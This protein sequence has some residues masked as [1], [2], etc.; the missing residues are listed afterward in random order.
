MCRLRNSLILQTHRRPG[1]HPCVLSVARSEFEE[2]EDGY[3]EG[4]TH[5]VPCTTHPS[6]EIG[7]WT[8]LGAGHIDSNVIHSNCFR[9]SSKTTTQVVF[10]N[11][12]KL[13]PDDFSQV[14]YPKWAIRVSLVSTKCR[15]VVYSFIPERIKGMEKKRGAGGTRLTFTPSLCH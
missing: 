13:R 14:R 15:H 8:H 1:L 7:A 11:R 3:P 9:A 5:A 2:T 10:V 12:V 4:P 6:L